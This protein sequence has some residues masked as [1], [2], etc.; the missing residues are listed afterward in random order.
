MSWIVQGFIVLVLVLFLLSESPMLS[1]KTIHFFARTS[2]DARSAEAT[3][4][5][6]NLQIRRFLLTKTLINIGVGAVVAL[7]LGA[8]GVKFAV[9]AQGCSRAWDEF[10]P[11]RR[12]RS[13]RRGLAH[14]GDLWRSSSRSAGRCSSPPSTR[15][16]S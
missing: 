10:R 9:A 5:G 1:R 3:L 8:I 15:P 6:L 7:A 13:S 14:A 11:L 2:K 12:P 16:S 4:R